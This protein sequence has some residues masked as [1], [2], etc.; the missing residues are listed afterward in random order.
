[1]PEKREGSQRLDPHSLEAVPQLASKPYNP[2]FFTEAGTT[3]QHY[4]SPPPD[5]YPTLPFLELIPVRFSCSIRAKRY[6]HRN[7]PHEEV[8]YDDVNSFERLDERIFDPSTGQVT[9]T[10]NMEVY[11]LDGE[12]Q[13]S[14]I[15]IA[16][17]RFDD[18]QQLNPYAAKFTRKL[19][20]AHDV[21]QLPKFKKSIALGSYEDVMIHIPQ[22]FA[23]QMIYRETDQERNRRFFESSGIKE[24]SIELR[25]TVENKKR[26]F[27]G[28]HPL[29]R[30]FALWEMYFENP[31]CLE[32]ITRD[33]NEIDGTNYTP[34]QVLLKLMTEGNYQQLLRQ[35]QFEQTVKNRI[36]EIDFQECSRLT[37]RALPE[38]GYAGPNYNFFARQIHA[39]Y[40]E[41]RQSIDFKNDAHAWE[42]FVFAA[43]RGLIKEFM[44]ML[45]NTGQKLDVSEEELVDVAQ[46]LISRLLREN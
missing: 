9:Y 42:F 13:V 23:K 46:E 30:N 25:D 27:N 12:S 32:I 5:K 36:L 33:M 21:P 7:F 43:T 11:I 3:I 35:R 2:P 26:F 14:L 29:P 45:R 39:Y 6:V 24:R 10:K 37:L 34:R 22:G 17:L 15:D 20:I 41:R 1:M 38:N 16:G 31:R 8:V 18:L 40:Q 28:T 44:D 4:E 19:F